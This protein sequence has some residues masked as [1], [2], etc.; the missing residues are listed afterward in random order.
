MY[1]GRGGGNAQRPWL[2]LGTGVALEAR[3]PRV[4]LLQPN[5]RC[6]GPQAG[7]QRRP[8]P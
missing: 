7:Q 5:L 1:E 6:P 2:V 8:L 3:F 4:P